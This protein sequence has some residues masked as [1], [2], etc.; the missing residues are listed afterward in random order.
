MTTRRRF[1]QQAPLLI[2]SL[3]P[4]FTQSAFAFTTPPPPA[5]RLWKPL[6][7]EGAIPR[8]PSPPRQTEQTE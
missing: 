6:E 4:L 5:K 3:S 1:L 8:Y 2:V 7:R